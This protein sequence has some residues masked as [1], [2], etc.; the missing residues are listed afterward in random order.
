MGNQRRSLTA[1]RRRRA[2]SSPPRR[3][4][5]D[6]ATVARA[7]SHHRGEGDGRRGREFESAQ[8]RRLCIFHEARKIKFCGQMVDRGRRT[9]AQH[10]DPASSN[11]SAAETHTL[12]RA[13]ACHCVDVDG[14]LKEEHV[15]DCLWE[16]RC[17]AAEVADG[18][19]SATGHSRTPLAPE[20]V[21]SHTNYLNVDDSASRPWRP[22]PSSLLARMPSTWLRTD[23]SRLHFADSALHGL[24]LGKTF[25]RN[26]APCTGH[27]HPWSYRE[28]YWRRDQGR[29]GGVQEVCLESPRLG[30]RVPFS[31]RRS[32]A[33][34][35]HPSGMP[36]LAPTP[37][38][39]DVHQ[40]RTRPL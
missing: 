14:C 18:L 4:N 22:P 23:H 36:P 7:R 40:C 21:A 38:T 12:T 8:Q 34:H 33:F 16:C 11:S 13:R 25:W 19:C 28:R 6:F 3:K 26:Q 30:R 10:Q 24:H 20:S 5:D 17:L 27:C 35:P 31:E 1:C 32:V 39:R 9:P 15:V 37:R 2:R 29:N